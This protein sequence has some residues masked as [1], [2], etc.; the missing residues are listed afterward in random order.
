M[1]YKMSFKQNQEVVVVVVVFSL[2]SREK[3]LLL[4]LLQKWLT[5]N[6]SCTIKLAKN[7][8]ACMFGATWC[9]WLEMVCCQSRMGEHLPFSSEPVIETTGNP[10][11]LKRI[12]QP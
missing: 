2:M 10:S 4:L 9:F 12:I 11:A 7:G 3:C 6:S 1:K 5:T 8:N